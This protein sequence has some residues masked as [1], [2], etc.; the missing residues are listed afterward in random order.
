[1]Y[2]KALSL[3]FIPP[4][5]QFP[6][7]FSEYKQDFS[8]M[9]ILHGIVITA[10][11]KSYFG[12]YKSDLD[13]WRSDYNHVKSYLSHYKGDLGHWLQSLWKLSQLLCIWF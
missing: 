6:T 5:E 7:F 3:Y 4:N 11:L 10:T 8:L 13:H 2:S 1:M 12:N 9:L